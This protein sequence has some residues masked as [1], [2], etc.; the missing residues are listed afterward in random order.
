MKF[1]HCWTVLWLLSLLNDVGGNTPCVAVNVSSVEGGEAVL[2]VDQ[3][4]IT[5]VSWVTRPDNYNIARTYQDG[6]I[7]IRGDKY[8]GKLRAERDGS[9]RITNLTREDR[10][11]YKAN[12]RTPGGHQCAEFILSVYKK[13]TEDDLQISHTAAG[14]QSCSV[15]VTCMVNRSDLTVT[16]ISSDSNMMVTG[17]AVSIEN[18]GANSTYTCTAWNPGS[19]SSKSIT[20]RSYCDTERSETRIRAAWET[21]GRLILSAAVL[22]LAA[23]FLICYLKG[24]RDISRDM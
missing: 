6:R 14:H 4:G 5:E 2:E 19:N 3:A 9:L 18:P 13:V 8:I 22:I 24:E 15:T 12:Q 21:R 16:W 1:C 7:Y 10:G 23:C 17:N 20:P 11:L